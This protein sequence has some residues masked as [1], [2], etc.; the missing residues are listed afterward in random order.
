ML[1]RLC[2]CFMR[3]SIVVTVQNTGNHFCVRLRLQI[4]AQH[5]MITKLFV[6]FNNSIMN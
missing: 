1:Y 5:K 2:N 6:I 4:F 3:I